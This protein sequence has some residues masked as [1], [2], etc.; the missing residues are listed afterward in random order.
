[1][2]KKEKLDQK[3]FYHVKRLTGLCRMLIFPMFFAAAGAFAYAGWAFMQ[4]PYVYREMPVIM[5]YCN[6][7][8]LSK[9]ERLSFMRDPDNIIARCQERT[10]WAGEDRQSVRALAQQKADDILNSLFANPKNANIVRSEA[11]NTLRYFVKG[12][13][14][15]FNYQRQADVSI[16]LA[17]KEA[18]TF[19]VKNQYLR[20]VESEGSPAWVA[21]YEGIW[22]IGDNQQ[23]GRRVTL[24]A[25]F[26][27]VFGESRNQNEQAIMV[28]EMEVSI[29]E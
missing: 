17:A 8:D 18:T 1:M 4:D 15:Y 21:K 11:T 19:K 22:V 6:E 12:S 26:S 23:G 16:V 20:K 28:R 24:Y 7:L 14:A 9:S 3:L 5:V 29:E 27:P 2:N 10:V 25:V 13:E